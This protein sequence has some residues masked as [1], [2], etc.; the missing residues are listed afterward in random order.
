MTEKR[1]DILAVDDDPDLLRLLVL[2]LKAAGY[3]VE[4]ATNGQEALTQLT[5][6]APRLLITDLRMPGM[7]GMALFDAV[8]AQRPGLPV[9][10]LTAHGTIPDAIQA[11]RDGVFGFLP[12]PFEPVELLTEVQ[13]ALAVSSPPRGS[14]AD[15]RAAI[16]TRSPKLEAVLDE[17]R[18]VAKSDVSVFVHGESGTGKE[19]LAQA[20]HKASPRHA[21]PFVPVNCGAIPSELLESELFG[22]VKGEIGRAHV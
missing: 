14:G 19:L 21:G 22:H 18:L 4:T 13:R 9:I 6:C 8:R 3:V 12:K 11:T 15:W 7:D 17:A 10:M 1:C 5:L 2:R 20:I 16:V